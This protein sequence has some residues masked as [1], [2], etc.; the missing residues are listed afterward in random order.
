MDF[1]VDQ[2]ACGQGHNCVLSTNHEI[3]CF[4]RNDLGQCGAGYTQTIGDQS[5][6]MGDD[7]SV[8]DLGTNFVPIQISCG[9]Q[10]SCALSANFELK[11]WGS[12]GE[13]QLGQE[14]TNNRGDDSNEMGDYLNPID[15]GTNFNISSIHSGARHNCAVSSDNNVK[16]WGQNGSG[17]LGLGDTSHR[18]DG[19]GEMGDALTALELSDDFEL[20]LIVAVGWT[21]LIVSSNGTVKAWGYGV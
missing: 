3:K 15:L 1:D 13:G 11:C 10:F 5:G 12:N 2:V 14:D 4:G 7:L 8:V 17:Q 16:C 21:N 20:R 9:Y 6:E 18:G 19:A